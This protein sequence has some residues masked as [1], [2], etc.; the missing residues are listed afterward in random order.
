MEDGEFNPYNHLARTGREFNP[1]DFL[2]PE[3][4]LA[5]EKDMLS[6]L[7]PRE[8][9]DI[10]M[11]DPRHPLGSVD[12]LASQQNQYE[13]M[14]K[15]LDGGIQ[16]NVVNPIS[17][18]GY[19]NLGAGIGA[20]AGAGT[21]MIPG[22]NEGLPFLGSGLGMALPPRKKVESIMDFMKPEAREVA[23]ARTKQMREELGYSDE[24]TPVLDPYANV[25]EPASPYDVMAKAEELDARVLD[26]DT[27]LPIE[28]R[29]PD[30]PLR[31]DPSQTVK[32]GPEWVEKTIDKSK[33]TTLD[34]MFDH[35]DDNIWQQYHEDGSMDDGLWDDWGQYGDE[36]E[37][38]TVA[39]ELEALT[40]RLRYGD[41]ETE[42][43]KDIYKHMDDD[44]LPQEF[45]DWMRA[46]DN[47]N[48]I[49]D[50]FDADGSTAE[51]QELQKEWA[52]EK[53]DGIVQDKIEQF[54]GYAKKG[55]NDYELDH[56]DPVEWD[57]NYDFDQAD[58]GQERIYGDRTR[59]R[60]HDQDIEY[61]KKR[62][63]KH[64]G[65]SEKEAQDISDAVYDDMDVFNQ[66]S[67]DWWGEY[68]GDNDTLADDILADMPDDH[69]LWDVDDLEDAMDRLRLNGVNVSNDD[70]RETIGGRIGDDTAKKIHDDT[71]GEIRSSINSRRESMFD[72]G[73]D[74]HVMTDPD[75]FLENMKTRKTGIKRSPRP[76]GFKPKIVP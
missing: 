38:P 17:K 1:W 65:F 24:P 54:D 33:R 18:A 64:D 16:E 42:I 14:L 4:R 67:D 45:R 7:P 69:D 20:M 40:D 25:S 35:P 8:W 29:A 48:G 50:D 52:K 41:Y 28:R 19:P 62:L 34:D 63:I 74:H 60:R 70:V 23:E 44:N 66:N 68:I 49:L 5:V 2:S 51:F 30:S 53:A 72:K 76:T 37:V 12:P 46:D 36:G 10:P 27:G 43:S 9:A 31:E 75:E 11:S 22:P 13:D 58:Y 47:Y 59:A 61:N 6:Q 26:P 15:D 73:K 3:E 55:G 39:D 21:E 71:I 56:M 57:N 32:V